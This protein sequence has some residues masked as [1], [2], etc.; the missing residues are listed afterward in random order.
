MQNTK[1]FWGQTLDDNRAHSLWETHNS[2]WPPRD[3]VCA[4]L[5][6]NWSAWQSPATR[7]VWFVSEWRARFP[8][9]WLPSDPPAGGDSEEDADAYA[10]ELVDLQRWLQENTYS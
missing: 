5:A 8:A 9:D 2:H 6:E 1:D 3:T 10:G 4:W 7:P